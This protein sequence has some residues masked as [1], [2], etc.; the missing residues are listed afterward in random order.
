MHTFLYLNLLRILYPLMPEE[1][2]QRWI[3]AIRPIRPSECVSAFTIPPYNSP[4]YHMNG[5]RSNLARRC[6]INIVMQYSQPRRNPKP[7][8][9]ATVSD[10]R[11]HFNIVT[12]SKNPNGL[13]K[14][15]PILGL[16]KLL[17]QITFCK[18]HTQKWVNGSFSQSSS[19]NKL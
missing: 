5:I 13:K 15:F 2:I 3:Y 7:S 12:H 11:T 16:S 14:G 17:D 9:R 18:L 19:N 10:F 6:W 8:E 4:S 1:Q